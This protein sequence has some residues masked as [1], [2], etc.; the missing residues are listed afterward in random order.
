MAW[1]LC[2]MVLCAKDKIVMTYVMCKNKRTKNDKK[3]R[4]HSD[5][6]ILNNQNDLNLYWKWTLSLILL[7]PSKNEQNT[8]LS[9]L[10]F[11][12][13]IRGYSSFRF[14]TFDHFSVRAFLLP[15]VYA[16]W[17]YYVF[18][19]ALSFHKNIVLHMAGAQLLFFLLFFKKIDSVSLVQNDI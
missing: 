13:I 7:P 11:I 10:S 16:D 12:P 4:H 15:L 8:K 6:G 1:S 5:Q 18:L 19:C 17:F 2:F 9:S 14:C 3:I